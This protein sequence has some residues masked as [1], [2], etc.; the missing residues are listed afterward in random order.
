MDDQLFVLQSEG[1]M[2]YRDFISD[3]PN[4]INTMN[5]WFAH[6]PHFRELLQVALL[7][8]HSFRNNDKLAYLRTLIYPKWYLI[9][10]CTQQKKSD[11]KTVEN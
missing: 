10:N 9:N 3:F 6:S 2:L 8:N 5:K 11:L 1:L 7:K 4:I